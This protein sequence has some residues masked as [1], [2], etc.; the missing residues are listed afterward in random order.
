MNTE[1][2]SMNPTVARQAW[3]AYRAAIKLRHTKEDEILMRGYKHLAQDKK[4]LDLFEVMKKAGVDS[5][6]RP[7]LAIARASWE[8]CWLY[9][10]A[11]AVTFSKNRFTRSNVIHNRVDLPD[12][13]LSH[14]GGAI[15]NLFARVPMIPP[16]FKPFGS[17]DNYHIL[18]D[19]QWEQETPSDP[20]LLRHLGRNIY[21][22]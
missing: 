22:V 4:I 13:V 20:I 3:Q 2:I 14:S 6:D 15:Y 8:K 19:A 10:S 21:A 9:K 7:Q 5:L 17:L 1:F 18:W 12:A 16:Q 11:G